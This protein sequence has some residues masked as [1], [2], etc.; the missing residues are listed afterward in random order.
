MVRIVNW[1]DRSPLL[2]IRKQFYLH[3]REQRLKVASHLMVVSGDENAT[4]PRG[5][6]IIIANLRRTMAGFGFPL[7]RPRLNY[8]DG[9]SSSLTRPDTQTPTK[10]LGHSIFCEQPSRPKALFDRHFR[11]T[12]SRSDGIDAKQLGQM[13]LILFRTP[14]RSC[15]MFVPTTMTD[16]II[17]IAHG[18][19][20][21]KYLERRSHVAQETAGPSRASARRDETRRDET[22]RAAS[23]KR[24][25]DRGN[26]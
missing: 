8:A 24:A 12:F 17:T 25:A 5:A 10:K 16:Q 14:Q 18:T 13:R 3:V 6:A 9:L 23:R 4:L 19:K 2:T 7:R 1:A 26:N 20:R 15:N 21:G 11:F 22:R